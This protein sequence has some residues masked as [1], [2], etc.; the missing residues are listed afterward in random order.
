MTIFK[1]DLV[2]LISKESGFTIKDLKVVYNATITVITRL[3]K[4]GT[5]IELMNFLKF[6][7]ER[8]PKRRVFSNIT[9]EYV[10]KEEEVRVKI[11][12]TFTYK[13]ILNEKEEV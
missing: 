8:I 11:K 2:R 13:K 3:M 9:N 12:P 6:T 5:S 7:P 1:D 10:N 4:E